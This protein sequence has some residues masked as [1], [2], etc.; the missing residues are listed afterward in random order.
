MLVLKLFGAALVMASSFFAGSTLLS[1]ERKKYSECEAFFNLI[2]RIRTDISCF[3]TPVPKIISEYKNKE[4]EE[5]GFTGFFDIS[6][7]EAL[8]H[9]SDKLHIDDETVKLLRRFGDELGS[10]YKDEQ[11]SSCDYYVERMSEQVEKLKNDLTKKQKLFRAC[12]LLAGALT[13]IIFI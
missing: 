5:C 9:C 10:S 1:F 6:F 4:L 11:I 3:N 12:S 13:V 8:E 2:R 7:N